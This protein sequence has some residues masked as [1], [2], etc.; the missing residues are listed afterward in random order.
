MS[1]SWS[2][3]QIYPHLGQ[4]QGYIVIPEADLSSPRPEGSTVSICHGA[5]TQLDSNPLRMSGEEEEEEENL[6]SALGS[7]DKVNETHLPGASHLPLGRVLLPHA[8]LDHHATFSQRR[9][10][11]V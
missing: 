11:G 4:D 5:I 6:T 1:N 7:L 10:G 9:G 8:R 2:K 3:T